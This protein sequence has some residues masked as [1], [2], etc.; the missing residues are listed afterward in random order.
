[1]AIHLITLQQ[2]DREPAARQPGGVD[3]FQCFALQGLRFTAEGA[4][5]QAAVSA[6]SKTTTL[7]DP[8]GKR[9]VADCLV[10]D[11]AAQARFQAEFGG[12]IYRFADCAGGTGREESGDFYL[13]LFDSDRLFRRLRSY[14]GRASLGP[15]LRGFV[16]PDLFKQFIEMTKKRA[17]DTVSL[18]SDCEREL[19]APAP[20]AAEPAPSVAEPEASG[21][22]LFSQLSAEKRILVKL[23]YIEDFELEPG[24]V[25]WLADRSR[26]SV[27]E[28]VELVEQAR[29]SVRTREAARREKLEEAESAAQWILRYERDLHH[30]A[31]ALANLPPQ[32]MRAERLREQQAELERKRAWRQQQHERALAENRR[33]TVTL[34]YREIADILNTPVGSVSAQVTR[35]RQELLQFVAQRSGERR[36]SPSPSGKGSSLP[37]SPSGRGSG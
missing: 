24:E 8:E 36:S 27:R 16:L 20:A 10:G 21:T 35:L 11:A 25:Q 32:S 6:E 37:P 14:E 9:L 15:F 13:Y 12:L 1:M 5:P 4:T 23:L 17:L 31:D 30:A 19:A 28:V 18:D 22:G 2:D 3:R 26:R 33:A 7:R 29:E 34:R